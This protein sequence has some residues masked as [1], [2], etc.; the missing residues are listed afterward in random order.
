[1]AWLQIDHRMSDHPVTYMVS[2]SALG[3]WLRCGCWIATF[4]D[5]GDTIPT[6]IAMR[7]GNARRRRELVD[8]GLW[9]E[10]EGGYAMRRSMNLAGSGLTDS[11]W[12]VAR[13]HGNRASIPDRLRQA[14]YE[15]D[16]FSCVECASTDDLTLDH[17]WP[18][19]KGG[20]DSAA[21]LRTLCRP[22]NSRKG[23]RV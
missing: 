3:L 14:I 22:C 10:V 11:I 18:W 12:D 5:H 21:N 20:S 23:A 4:P 8:S 16:G 2:D 6:S 9:V 19:S 1:M 15:R 13:S 17:I 7:Y